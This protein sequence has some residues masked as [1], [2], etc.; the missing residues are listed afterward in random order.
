MPPNAWRVL[1]ALGLADALSKNAILPSS[2][3]LG[4]AHSGDILVEMPVN[5]DD[6]SGQN[7]GAIHRAQLHQILWDAAQE[8]ERIEIVTGCKVQ[9]IDEQHGGVDVLSENRRWR[10]EPT[11]RLFL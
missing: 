6:R 8:S 11:Q 5:R 10:S 3:C 4:D 2:I 9:R 1:S 7:F